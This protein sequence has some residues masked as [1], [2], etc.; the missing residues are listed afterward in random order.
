MELLIVRHGRSLGDDEGRI[1]GGGWDAP[2]TAHGHWQA[3]RLA[4]RLQNDGYQCDLL[5]ASPLLRTQAVAEAVAAA[6]HLPVQYDDRLR[7]LHTG[8]IGGLTFAEAEQVRPHPP[9]GVRTWDRI[10]EGECYFDQVGR[11]MRFYAELLDKQGD[12]SVCLVTHGGTVS[13]LLQVILGLPMNQPLFAR[14]RVRFRVGDTSLHRLTVTQDQA[15]V[16]YLNDTA[17]LQNN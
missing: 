3:A 14:Q 13:I 6:L 16:H 7:E 2:L 17:H 15:V 4:A 10:P 8:I 5:Y 12:K 11:V 9:G 1:E